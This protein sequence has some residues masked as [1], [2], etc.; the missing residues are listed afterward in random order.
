MTVPCSPWAPGNTRTRQEKQ[1][2]SQGRVAVWGLGCGAW[3]REGRVAEGV[4]V[5]KVVAV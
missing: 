5:D 4:R 1:G 2:G 3:V